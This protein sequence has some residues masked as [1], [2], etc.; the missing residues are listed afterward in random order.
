M[1]RSLQAYKPPHRAETARF[2]RPTAR[3]AHERYGGGAVHTLLTQVSPVG[4]VMQADVQRVPALSSGAQLLS[5]HRWKSALHAGTHDVPLQLTVPF[6]GAVQVVQLGPHAAAVLFAT[7][8]GACAV[9]R[10]QKPGALHSTRQLKVGLVAV[11]HTAMPSLG[12]AGHA[13]HDVPQL[14]VERSDTHGPVP[15]GQR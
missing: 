8:V 6:A 4:H 5:G 9:P 1:P 14:L 3:L 11:S 7:Q 2:S 13:V 15:A 12:G 10:K